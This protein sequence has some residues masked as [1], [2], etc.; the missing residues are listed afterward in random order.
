MKS[1]IIS[2]EN[3]IYRFKILQV[4]E[5]TFNMNVFDKKR[6]LFYSSD[7]NLNVIPSIVVLRDILSGEDKHW[8]TRYMENPESLKIEFTNKISKPEVLEFKIK[9]VNDIEILKEEVEMLKESLF[10]KQVVKYYFH[11]FVCVKQGNF[12]H[13]SKEKLNGIMSFTLPP[14]LRPMNTQ[15]QLLHETNSEC[16]YIYVYP[17]GDVEI[18]NSSNI[19]HLP[20]S[21][22]W[23]VE[24]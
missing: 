16:S 3:K 12:V 17:S 4:S 14:E 7:F 20:I 2:A 19:E 15:Y 21:M 24:K 11:D 5:D 6:R 13:L 8:N 10:E 23:V 22:T 18:T 9:Q 1:N